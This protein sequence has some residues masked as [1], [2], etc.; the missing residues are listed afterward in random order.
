MIKNLKFKLK[1]S[2]KGLSLVELLVSMFI[3]VL[4]MLVITSVFIVMVKARKEAREMQKNM[5]NLRSA[6]E[7][8]AKNIRMSSVDY[9]DAGTVNAHAIYIYNHSQQKCMVFYFPG[10]ATK[11]IKFAEVAGTREAMS[12]CSSVSYEG[13]DKYLAIFGDVNPI[14][15]VDFYYNQFATNSTLGK[16]T[17]SARM[18][19]IQDSMQTTVSLR[20]YSSITGQ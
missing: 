12:D 15:E 10:V 1:N 19:G 8:M 11:S 16:V 9:P 5:E 14:Q 17:I 4:I 13:L 6:I 20:N 2:S 7:F 3:F 18:Q